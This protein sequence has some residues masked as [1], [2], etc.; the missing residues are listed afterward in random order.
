MRRAGDHRREKDLGCR[1]LGVKLRVMAKDYD[2]RALKMTA[3]KVTRCSL[4]V[5]QL[6]LL[7]EPF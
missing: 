3:A 2:I 1:F 6:C 7:F 4:P 5:S